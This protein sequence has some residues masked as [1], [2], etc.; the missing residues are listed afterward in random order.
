MDPVQKVSFNREGGVNGIGMISRLREGRPKSQGMEES[1]TRLLFGNWDR[2][3]V[4]IRIRVNVY[5]LGK[6][7]HQLELDVLGE[8]KSGINEELKKIEKCIQ[9]FMKS[10][11][12][13]QIYHGYNS[14]ERQL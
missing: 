4:E 6:A 2:I 3:S 12:E 13:G 1:H 8:R 11:S 10:K 9:Q 14:K 5:R 7:V